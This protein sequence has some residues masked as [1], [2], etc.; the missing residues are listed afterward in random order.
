MDGVPSRLAVLADIHG[1]S[2]ALDVVLAHARSRD[3]TAFLDAGDTA[4]G[5][6]DPRGTVG[7]LMA[8]PEPLL[9]V[10]G[11]GDRALWESPHLSPTMAWTHTQLTA[12]QIEWLRAAPALLSW[13][14]IVLFHG[15]PGNDSAYLCESIEGGGV[16]RRPLADIADLVAPFP[17][18]LFICG[19]SHLPSLIKLG[20]GRQVLDPG[21]VGLQAYADE[22]PVPH[23]ISNGSPH[24][25][26]ALIE[27]S[28]GGWIVEHIA[29]P[30]DYE[31]AAAEAERHERP[32]W[33]RA[34]RTGN[35]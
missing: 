17:A 2:W 1:N 15:Q 24:A 19:H 16:L 22:E 23:T 26:Y 20:D 7:R 9:R 35:V 13:R 34:L 27:R 6:L 12:D 4:Y 10:N 29:L 18:E 25:R 28:A 30:Y 33:A 8:L 21:S 11:N 14:D 32:D 31:A 3:A 5:P